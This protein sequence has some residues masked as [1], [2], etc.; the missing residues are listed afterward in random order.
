[1]KKPKI[2]FSGICKQYFIED[3]YDPKSFKSD[4]NTF[5]PDFCE[6]VTD[7]SEFLWLLERSLSLSV[8]E[9]IRVLESLP[10]LSK[11]K[12]NN[13]V[14][15]WRDE[16][17]E[18]SKRYEYDELSIEELIINS[19]ETWKQV[20]A[21]WELKEKRFALPSDI[22]GFLSPTAIKMLLDD[23]VIGQQEATRH[24][25][26]ALYYQQVAIESIRKNK[27]VSFRPLGPLLLTGETGSGK[28]FIMQKG[29]ELLDLP[30]VQ[31]DASSMVQEG[32]VG[33][34][35]NDLGKLLL[36][37]TSENQQLAEHAVVLI[38]EFDKL[39]TSQHGPT[40]VHQL[41]RILEGGEIRIT[42]GRW[43]NVQ[44][45]ASTKNLKTHNM[46]FILGGAFQSFFDSQN[47]NGVGFSSVNQEKRRLELTLDELSLQGFP[48]E[49]VGR[50]TKIVSLNPLGE[51]DF[52]KILRDSKSSPLL[53]F[54]QL[55][56]AQGSTLNISEREMRTIAQAAAK[57]G[58]GARGI[59]HALY[60]NLFN[61]MF[62]GNLLPF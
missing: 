34:S 41:L 33:F 45:R 50:V 21:K 4:I 51:D 18:F 49:L 20:K 40:V 25:A 48:K 14:Q 3:V 2:K 11:I 59:K 56:E 22:H 1:M 29:C 37:I 15:V 46:L 27:D 52:Y 26:L 10:R 42:A 62:D 13:L 35:I 17:V 23:H 7:K 44:E 60:N 31:I 5:Y 12:I 58:L 9:K 55:M 16:Q 24:I 61:E 38:D 39:L 43:D 32:I 47:K 6:L 54:N 57:S 30:F 53:T 28:T 19:K 8:Y 36:E